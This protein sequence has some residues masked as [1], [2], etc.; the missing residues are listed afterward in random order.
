[1]LNYNIK[2]TGLEVSDDIRSYVEKNLAHVEKFLQNDSTAHIDVEVKY[3]PEGRSGKYCAEFTVAAAGSIYRAEHW[4]SALHE[5]ID[6]A[7]EELMAELRRAKQKR[8]HVVRRSAGRVKEYLRG[9][10]NKI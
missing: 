2:G 3:L 9:W 10:R 8:I 4:G 1:M 6:L 7:R 5:A